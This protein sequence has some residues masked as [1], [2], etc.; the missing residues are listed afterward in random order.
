MRLQRNSRPYKIMKYALLGGGF[1]V[2]SILAPASGSKIITGL[3]RDYIKRKRFQKGEFLQ[4]LRR[5]QERRL[6]DYQELD[7]GQVKITLTK[8]GKKES[9][10]YNLDDIKL[11]SERWDG[12]WRLVMFD[13]PHSKKKAREALRGKLKSIG[14]YP[15][16]KSVFLTPY[17]CEKEID[18]MCS[19]FEV[20]DHVLVFYV[21]NFEGEEKL[22]HHFKLS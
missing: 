19:I 16:Q 3:I 6:I 10:V 14:F 9:L 1:L 8:K 11:D 15:I 22:K 21:G 17:E 5:L 2:L 7:G 4:D 18:F 20:R 13:I 12:K